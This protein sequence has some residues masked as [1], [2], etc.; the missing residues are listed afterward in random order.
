MKKLI[1]AVALCSCGGGI[2]QARGP[3]DPAKQTVVTIAGTGTVADGRQ[4]S[5]PQCGPKCCDLAG[6]CVYCWADEFCA[7]PSAECVPLK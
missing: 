1:L 6:N 2:D 4:A 5:L 7:Q 3:C